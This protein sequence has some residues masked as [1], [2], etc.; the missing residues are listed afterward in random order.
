[1]NEPLFNS[2]LESFSD[3]DTSFDKSKRNDV[4]IVDSVNLPDI[5]VWRG[6]KLGKAKSTGRVDVV[7]LP[8]ISQLR[9]IK[10]QEAKSTGSAPEK[11]RGVITLAS[12]SIVFSDIIVFS[13]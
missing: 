2:K 12:N 6:I 5:S 3:I 7:N 13:D 10:V 8:D 9:R 4:A 11:I 1:M